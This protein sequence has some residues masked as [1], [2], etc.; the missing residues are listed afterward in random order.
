MKQLEPKFTQAQ[1]QAQA[2]QFK[3]AISTLETILPFAS[4][5]VM[6]K[7]QVHSQIGVFH[8][9][10]R[11]EDKALEHLSQGSMR[12]PDAQLILASIHFKKDNLEKM[13]TALDMTIKLNKKQILLYNAYAFMLNRKGLNEEAIQVLQNGLKVDPE[14]DTTKDN[15]LRLQNNKKMNMKPFGMNWYTLQLE[16]PPLSMMQDQFS[17]KAGFRQPKRKKS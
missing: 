3:L 14:N 5:Q 8:F 2:R 1:K 9:A 4:W 17:G 11:N 12:T 7:S 16:K 13:R 15:L 10:D 6:L